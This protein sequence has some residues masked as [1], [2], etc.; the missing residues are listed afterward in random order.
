MKIGLVLP[1]SRDP[2]S[3]LVRLWE[4]TAK[5]AGCGAKI[6]LWLPGESP[7]TAA[8]LSL[9]WQAE[10]IFCGTAERRE[11]YL[12][13]PFLAWLQI[14]YQNQKPD[15]MVFYGSISGH[16]LAVRLSARIDCRCLTEVE[17]LW[18]EDNAL[19]AEKKV[20]SSHLIW[21]DT[22][23]KFPS[24]VSVAQGKAKTALRAVSSSPIIEAVPVPVE[25]T[26]Y[27]LERQELAIAAQNLL[28]TA[29]FVMVG[30]RGL[31]NKAGYQKLADCAARLGAAIGLS[32]PA[33]LNGWGSLE[34]L[35]GQSGMRIAPELCVVLGVSGSTAFVTGV[36]ASQTLIAVNIDKDAPIFKHADVGIV[37][38]IE[39]L[40]DALSSLASQDASL[41]GGRDVSDL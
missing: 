14:V 7:V 11:E 13:E 34:E 12:P 30:G 22:V 8:A 10:T 6:S 31:G 18:F 5:C 17:E 19:R 4:A 23:K 41:R 38:N 26:S 35:I 3:A 39:P 16:E 29:S 25:T 36:E 21:Q 33:A 2:S 20:C 37:A 24:I 9:P 15:L 1:P 32:R 28:K 40:L 27:L